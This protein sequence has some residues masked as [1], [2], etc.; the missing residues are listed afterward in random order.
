MS[1]AYCT[2]AEIGTLGVNPGAISDIDPTRKAQAIA[3]VSDHIDGYLASQFTLPLISWGQDL[4]EACAVL[5]AAQLLRTRGTSYD[6]EDAFWSSVKEKER[7]LQNIAR[8][9]VTPRVVDSAAGGKVGVPS[10]VPV[11]ASAPSQGFSRL[12]PFPG[13]GL[14]GSNGGG[15]S[16]GS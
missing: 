9:F 7:W 14:C 2:V 4:R 15:G 6:P 16:F 3:T 1:A 13:S 12:T 5:A 8:R 11:I 10:S